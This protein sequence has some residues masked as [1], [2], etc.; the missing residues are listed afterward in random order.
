MRTAEQ[1]KDHG[2]SVKLKSQI[3]VIENAWRDSDRLYADDKP[4]ISR[5]DIITYLMDNGS[6]DANA[7]QEVKPSCK[8]R[9]IHSLID[10]NIIKKKDEQ[11]IIVDKAV[12][13]IINL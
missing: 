4:L 8:G 12:L 11:Y 10:N 1:P 13:S 2:M 6:T 5:Q 3:R 9:L 7:K